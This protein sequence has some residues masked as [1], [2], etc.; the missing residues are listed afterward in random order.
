MESLWLR[1]SWDS[2]EI[3]MRSG[4]APYFF[5]F[6]LYIFLIS[7]YTIKL[8]YYDVRREEKHGQVQISQPV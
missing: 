8:T 1:S 2:V 6:Y 7:W 4:Y 3:K 5:I